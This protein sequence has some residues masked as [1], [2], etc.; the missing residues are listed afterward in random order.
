MLGAFVFDLP[1][2]VLIAFACGYGFVIGICQPITMSWISLIAP[3]GTRALAMSMRLAANRLGQTVLPATLGVLAAAAGAAGVLGASSVMLLIA[4]G[5]GL[6]V[7]SEPAAEA[8]P[9]EEAS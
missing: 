9:T 5:A 3:V 4:A 7:P 6:G 2:G 8:Q 1:A